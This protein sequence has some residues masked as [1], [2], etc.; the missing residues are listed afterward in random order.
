[1]IQFGLGRRAGK[2]SHLKMSCMHD[3]LS[4]EL[5]QVSELVPAHWNPEASSVFGFHILPCSSSPPLPLLKHSLDSQH[6]TI[7]SLAVRNVQRAVI[8]ACQVATCQRLV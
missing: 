4:C 6:P 2:S 7:D 8:W 3:V 1:V 5:S